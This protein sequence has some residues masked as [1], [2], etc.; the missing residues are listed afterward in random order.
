MYKIDS[1]RFTV[2]VSFFGQ[3]T[4]LTPTLSS[5]S[6]QPTLTKAPLLTRRCRI[7]KSF[8]LRF[9]D[10]RKSFY[11]LS[12]LSVATPKLDTVC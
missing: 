6:A 12:L 7:S 8:V 4:I 5:T 3:A 11:N 9:R 10:V 1:R 2:A